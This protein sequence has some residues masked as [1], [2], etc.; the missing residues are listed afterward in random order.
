VTIF[1][2]DVSSYEAGLDLS[3]LADASF[4]FAKASEGTYYT[5]ASYQGW[6]RQAASLG[7]PFAW[8]HFLS[9]EG[10]AA[11][12]AHTK[13]CIGDVGLPGMLDFEPTPTMRPTLSQAL[14]YADAAHA[15]GLNL[16]LVYLPHWYWQQLGS[17]SLSGLTSRGLYLVSSNYPGGTGNPERLYPGDS[18]SGWQPYGGVTPLI[19][20][21]TDKA[22]DGG[23]T[24]DF[25]AFRG[26]VAQL[27]AYLGAATP[28]TTTG[29]AMSTIPATIGQ[30]WPEIASE[31][32]ANAAY[33]DSGA[34]IWADGGARAAAL[35]A[36]QARDA[37]NALAAKVQAP[38]PIDVPALAA[39]LA[40]LLTQ[41]A[42]ADQIATAVVGHLATALAKG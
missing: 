37:V 31:F 5:D 11:Q 12:V 14:A 7:L 20:Q 32:P 25:N 24:E 9:T 19:Y 41:G 2:P 16:R 38:P 8:Y 39:A 29:G 1:G 33:D 6:R 3:K 26:S 4:V 17:P 40:P 21:Y 22:S 10:A 13:A 30:K 34:I 23:K 27:R 36:R 28:T 35:Y 42:T 18:A 15:A